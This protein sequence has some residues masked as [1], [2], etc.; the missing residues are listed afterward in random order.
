MP[1]VIRPASVADLAI[2]VTY[3]QRMALET[4]RRE[5]NADVLRS[6]VSAVLRDDTKGSYFVAEENGEVVG[7]TMITY[8]WSDWRNGMFWWIQSVYVREDKRG[9]GVFSALYRHIEQLARKKGGVCG[10]RLYAEEDNA[11]AERTYVKL[12]MTKTS[13]RLFE[14]ELGKEL[15]DRS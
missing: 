4:E 8:E 1:L 10:L 15:G 14:V 5:L 2:I 3:N 11:R 13:Y 6:G 7:Q 9:A 12:G